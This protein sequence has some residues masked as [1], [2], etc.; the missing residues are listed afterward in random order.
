MN[1]RPISLRGAG[2]LVANEPVVVRVAGQAVAGESTFT[3]GGGE[4]R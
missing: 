3:F 2:E 4:L 1:A